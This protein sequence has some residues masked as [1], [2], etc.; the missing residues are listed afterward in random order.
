MQRKKRR[1]KKKGSCLLAYLFSWLNVFWWDVCVC[2]YVCVYVCVC[3]PLLKSGAFHHQ[4]HSD[5][6]REISFCPRVF[7]PTRDSGCCCVDEAPLPVHNLLFSSCRLKVH[8]FLYPIFSPLPR[9]MVFLLTS[10]TWGIGCLVYSKRHLLLNSCLTRIHH[11]FFG[12]FKINFTVQ[13]SW[14]RQSDLAI[15][16]SGGVSHTSDSRITAS[17]D[18]TLTDWELQIT[19]AQTK[20]SVSRYK[21]STIFIFV[22]LAATKQID[23]HVIPP[24][25]K[26][27][28][29]MPFVLYSTNLQ[30]IC[31][32]CAYHGMYFL[33][34]GSAFLSLN[35]VCTNVKSTPSRK[36]I[37]PLPS[38]SK[39]SLTRHFYFVYTWTGHSNL[40]RERKAVGIDFIAPSIHVKSSM[41][42]WLTSWSNSI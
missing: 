35:R 40:E 18:E 5:S 25:N 28:S 1:D 2:V 15:L 17:A 36:S 22:S 8:H 37:G 30:C 13:V 29:I 24:T 26:A 21:H 31:I 3:R 33:C 42:G 38:T 19:E 27:T 11:W 14:V 10:T 23:W 6:Q 4:K 41:S 20:D 16:A 7:Y 34:N 32:P 39:V 9:P 12:L